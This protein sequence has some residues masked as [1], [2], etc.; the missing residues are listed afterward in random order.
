MSSKDNTIRIWDIRKSNSTLACLRK[1][2]PVVSTPAADTSSRKGKA[3]ATAPQFK[4]SASTLAKF[5]D[6]ILGLTYTHFSTHLVSVNLIGTFDIWEREEGGGGAKHVATHEIP[7]TNFGTDL[8]CIIPVVPELG[9]TQ[10]GQE[11][12]VIPSVGYGLRGV[13]MFDVHT[14]DIV[15]L[16]RGHFG[17][18]ACAALRQNSQQLYSGGFDG[19]ILQWSPVYMKESFEADESARNVSALEDSWS[20]NGK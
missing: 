1:P 19:E 15:S 11:V 10:V 4:K 20:D 5:S 8:N 9:S 13:G 3:S 18:N 2:P 17:R 6:V 14:G 7:N 12:V 16:L